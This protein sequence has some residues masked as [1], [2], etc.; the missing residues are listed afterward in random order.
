MQA[1]AESAPT[2]IPALYQPPG[3]VLRCPVDH[4]GGG[5]QT[6]A[7]I[8]DDV[9]EQGA[10]RLGI[11]AILTAVSVV[12]SVIVKH[13]LQPELAA[14]QSTPLFRLS[15]LFLVLASVGLAAFQHSGSVHPQTLLNLGLVFEV[16]GAFA[17]AAME[18]ALAWGETPIRGSTFVAAWI[19]LCA[20]VIPNS[21]W[22]SSATAFL[23]AAMVP[24]AHLSAAEIV[25][26]PIMP[27]N[28]LAS[29]SLGP[30]FVAAWIPFISTRLHRMRE[31]L[32]HTRDLG[33]YSLDQLLGKGGMGEVWRARHRLLR[34]DAAV[35]LVIPDLLKRM[36][37]GER[38][39]VQQRFEQEAQA[40]ASLRSPRTI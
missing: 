24:M 30:V 9:A 12:A 39:H 20:L 22:K 23:S 29:Y 33:S 19:A 8:R 13:L 40:T 27:W 3:G 7:R 25:S 15:A 10:R 32:S 4:R 2:I 21:P 28:R 36:G 5:L 26:Y 1:A 34:R 38:Q 6:K 14:A 16:A 37:W 31:E 11:L 17:I 35:K 18:N